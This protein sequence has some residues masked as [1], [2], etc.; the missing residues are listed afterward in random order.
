MLETHME[1]FPGGCQLPTQWEFL[2]R[3]PAL[4]DGPRRPLYTSFK[5]SGTR[6]DIYTKLGILTLPASISCVNYHSAE[7]VAEVIICLLETTL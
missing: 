6:I 3:G 7:K 2:S 4:G 5:S 1:I